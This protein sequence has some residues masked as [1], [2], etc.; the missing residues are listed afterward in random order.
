MVHQHFM[1]ADQ[2]T[3]LENVILGPNQLAAAAAS[4]A[5]P[6]LLARCRE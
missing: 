3:V 1:L 2:L 6:R 4:F 5:E